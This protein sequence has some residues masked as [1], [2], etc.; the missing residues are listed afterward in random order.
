M[1]A[2]DWDA[3]FAANGGHVEMDLNH[4]HQQEV[5]QLLAGRVTDQQIDDIVVALDLIAAQESDRRKRL[6]RTLKT[7]STMGDI[8]LKVFKA[9]T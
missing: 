3:L 8:G 5:E 9:V 6:A 4:V 7:L 2:A 1:S